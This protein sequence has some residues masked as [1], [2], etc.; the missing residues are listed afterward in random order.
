VVVFGSVTCR[1]NCLSIRS[2]LSEFANC[3]DGVRSGGSTAPDSIAGYYVQNCKV[4]EM[5]GDEVDQMLATI[6]H[7]P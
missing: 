2:P 1:Y 5:G 6:R 3:L 4:S 7:R